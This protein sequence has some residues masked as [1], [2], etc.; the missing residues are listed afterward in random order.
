MADRVSI[1]RIPGPS[2]CVIISAGLAARSVWCLIS[3][4]ALLHRLRLLWMVPQ[5]CPFG[6]IMAGD[7]DLVLDGRK[8]AI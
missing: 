4:T 8:L 3:A 1:W 7:S 2:D 5:D 6:I